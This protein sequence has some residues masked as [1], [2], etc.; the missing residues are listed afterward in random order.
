[1]RVEAVEA[2]E[3]LAQQKDLVALVVAV[4]EE[5]IIPH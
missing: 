3:V 2:V 4:M 5:K 1:M